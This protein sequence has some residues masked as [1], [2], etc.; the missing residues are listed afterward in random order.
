MDQAYKRNDATLPKGMIYASFSTWTAE[1]LK[2][3]QDFKERSTQRANKA[4][5]K[6]DEELLKMKETNNLLQK[7]LHYYNALCA[8]DDYFMEPNTKMKGV[9]SNDEVAQFEGD[10]F[11]SKNGKVWTQNSP[12]GKG[13]LLGTVSLELMNKDM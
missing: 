11:V 12:R 1:G 8:A 4:L 9:P 6:K 10:M 7:G 5:K 13:V 2:Q 3:A